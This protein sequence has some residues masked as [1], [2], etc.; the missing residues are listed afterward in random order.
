MPMRT[1]RRH[2]QVQ[3]G[4][5]QVFSR[6][7]EVIPR[8]EDLKWLNRIL[9]YTTDNLEVL[10]E[11]RFEALSELRRVV[12]STSNFSASYDPSQGTL[13]K[14]LLEGKKEALNQERYNSQRAF[15]LLKKVWDLREKSLSDPATTLS[16]SVVNTVIQSASLN[17]GAS[18]LE[19]LAKIRSEIN[20]GLTTALQDLKSAADSLKGIGGTF[21]TSV[22]RAQVT[23]AKLN[24]TEAIADLAETREFT[25][26]LMREQMLDD[27]HDIP[28]RMLVKLQFQA[29]VSPG[30]IDD[31]TYKLEL[32][33]YHG[34]AGKAGVRS[35]KERAE[36]F[37]SLWAVSLKQRME[38][39]ALELARRWEVA[40][41]LDVRTMAQTGVRLDRL[42]DLY[43]N[44]LVDRVPNIY[45]YMEAAGHGIG[46]G[47][48]VKQFRSSLAAVQAVLYPPQGQPSAFL[49][50]HTATRNRLFGILAMLTK[51]EEYDRALRSS[52]APIQV[53]WEKAR[54]SGLREKSNDL[55][56]VE[57]LM[58]RMKALEEKIDSFSSQPSSEILSFPSTILGLFEY[59]FLS[60]EGGRGKT[61]SPLEGRSLASLMK[62]REGTSEGDAPP[63]NSVFSSPSSTATLLLDA[64]LSLMRPVVEIPS[65]TKE[66]QY[67]KFY[68]SFLSKDSAAILSVSPKE[69]VQNISEIS[70]LQDSSALGVGLRALLPTK[71]MGAV[72]G[73]R[74][75]EK[76]QRMIN[77]IRRNPLV[78]GFTD[79]QNGFGWYFGPR[80]VL[81]AN[82]QSAH[83]QQHADYV[84]SVTMSVPE[85]WDHLCLTGQTSRINFAGQRKK[86]R[87][88]WT[89]V[90]RL[91]LGYSSGPCDCAGDAGAHSHGRGGTSLHG[92]RVKLPG[93]LDGFTDQVLFG[94]R[95]L[96]PVIDLARTFGPALNRRNRPLRLKS[97]D[98]HAAFLIFGRNLWRNPEVFLGGIR[99]DVTILP[100]MEALQIQ[101]PYENES[102]SL[103][104]PK[105]AL[106]GT[107]VNGSEIAISRSRRTTALGPGFYDL[108]VVTSNGE[109]RV[110]DAIEVLLTSPP[111]RSPETVTPGAELLC[112]VVTGDA[113][114]YFRVPGVVRDTNG[115]RIRFHPFSSKQGT[116]GWWEGRLGVASRDEGSSTVSLV[117]RGHQGKNSS[118]FQDNEEVLV[119]EIEVET[120]ANRN[121]RRSFLIHDLVRGPYGQSFTYFSN[122]ERTSTTSQ[123]LQIDKKMKVISPAL[124]ILVKKEVADVVERTGWRPE[125]APSATMYV[126]GAG[127]FEIN[128]KMVR[129]KRSGKGGRFDVDLT[130]LLEGTANPFSSLLKEKAAEKSMEFLFTIGCIRSRKNT[131]KIIVK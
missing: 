1:D 125:E 107:L 123:A 116:Q 76:A 44:F 109:D 98:P 69:K 115:E 57:T 71:G 40:G 93:N 54:V 131:V 36:E 104:D 102:A 122:L 13:A 17:V 48:V 114:L 63:F 80:F 28:G 34:G 81:K 23:S 43:W 55:R 108:F 88:L 94:H 106:R 27:G 24:I 46:K 60:Q 86:I 77:T 39:E 96:P 119:R 128:P 110:R 35:E 37:L 124:K 19:D 65:D 111:P 26:R 49:Q 11:T 58:M 73:W 87:R 7:A 121:R 25:R 33:A 68:R 126:D 61:F 12:Q 38:K 85:W 90:P 99:M 75:F 6:E 129:W 117:S 14:H 91:G 95:R 56:S 42:L 50:L 70:G 101:L 89:E 52:T 30:Y 78:V 82:G 67:R 51:M 10:K 53:G 16:S 59:D 9:L 97:D 103:G 118:T 45:A 8:S 74:E 3:I 120:I 83:R 64:T 112:S 92:I 113:P 5:P 72:A 31:N 32:D 18:F 105:A 127:P 130:G 66:E 29:S 20:S 47:D 21:L 41:D 15:E 4:H 79:G 2:G 22:P 62:L 100:S 84:V